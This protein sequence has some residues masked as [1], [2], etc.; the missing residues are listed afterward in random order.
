MVQTLAKNFVVFEFVHVPREQNR[1]AYLLSKLASCTKLGQHKLVIR[2][3]IMCPRVDMGEKLQVMEIQ[4]TRESWM[5]PINNYLTD[6]QLPRD[7][8]EVGRIKKN[9]SRYTLIDRNLFRYGF[10]RPFL[11]CVDMAEAT[12]IVT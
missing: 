11:I 4:A 5:T 1:L 8:E 6:N 3:T 12:Q 9:S 7:V 10:S 2:E